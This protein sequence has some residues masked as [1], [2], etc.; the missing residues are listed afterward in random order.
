MIYARLR[1]D[2]YGGIDWILHDEGIRHPLIVLT[3]IEMNQL[4]QEVYKQRNQLKAH[5]AEVKAGILKAVRP[6]KG[7]K[8]KI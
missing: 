3:D 4:H 8:K 5:Q 2:V 7:T 6:P 1:R